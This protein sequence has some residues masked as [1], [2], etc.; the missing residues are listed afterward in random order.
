M[1]IPRLAIYTA[2]H[3]T[4]SL[5]CYSS[6]YFQ[7]IKDAGFRGIQAP[8]SHLSQK[9]DLQMNLRT[10]LQQQD[11]KL[12]VDIQ[13]KSI[14]NFNLQLDQISS[15]GN[16]V[17]HINCKPCFEQ[18][19]ISKKSLSKENIE[20]YSDVLSTSAQFLEEH[21]YIGKYGRETDIMG[22]S[23]HHLTGISHDILQPG[24]F[25]TPSLTRDMLE[26]L[27]PF[28]LTASIWEW[29]RDCMYWGHDGV[30]CDGEDTEEVLEVEIV[31]HLDH[32]H[33]LYGNDLKE[34]C[35]VAQRELWSK[36]W[37]RK[38]T[39]NVEEVSITPY[40]LGGDICREDADDG[41]LWNEMLK[42][43]KEIENSYELWRNGYD[44]TIDE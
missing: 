19:E 16:I 30:V 43:K 31:P 44:C 11:L 22:N 36:V 23:P 25:G 3:T 6:K 4:N 13:L 41:V 26:V 33:V 5:K 24:I 37:S 40:I 28:R 34:E 9:K 15:L 38:A 14:D 39:R 35:K 42:A 18:H 29:Y 10:E 8:L 1:A 21:S 12:I 17:T 20:F 27:P 2:N 7:R 32:I